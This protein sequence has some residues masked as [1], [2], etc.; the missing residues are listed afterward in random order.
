MALILRRPRVA[1]VVALSY[2]RML[3]LPR[4][5]FRDFLRSHPDL[6]QRVRKAAEERLRQLQIEDATGNGLKLCFT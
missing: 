3:M 2:C 5:A 4:D 6:M 1:D